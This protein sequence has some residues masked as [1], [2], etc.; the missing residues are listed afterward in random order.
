MAYDLR[1]LTYI[2]SDREA[3]CQI[4]SDYIDRIADNFIYIYTYTRGD[5]LKAT[6]KR[7]VFIEYIRYIA[8]V[9]GIEKADI[10]A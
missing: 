9:L 1:K 8:E 4:N 10:L 3:N 6:I 7:A 5:L 2:Y